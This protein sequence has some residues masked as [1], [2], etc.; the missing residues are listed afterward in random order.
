[1]IAALRGTLI[2][3]RDDDLV[4]D[5]GGVGYQV[6]ATS[7][8]LAS[9]GDI[10]SEVQLVVHTDV[11]ET[12][13]SLFGFGSQLEKE[14]FLMLRKVKGV[15]S[16]LALAIVSSVGAEELLVSIGQSDVSAL[17]K[18]SGVGKKT[19]ERVIV[20]LRESVTALVEDRGI[21]VSASAAK[22]PVTSQMGG[23]GD[24]A[25]LALQRL[26]FSKERATSAVERSLTRELSEPTRDAGE[27]VKEA[28][29][30]L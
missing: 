18:V 25:V 26:G 20:E 17:K 11:K 13:I 7:A 22:S 24:D 15:G 4:I 28:L 23:A 16:R 9:V 14:V 8:V 6:T 5:T 27:L 3:R 10:G 19:A 2:Q 1:M 12:S 21:S 30:H 29:A